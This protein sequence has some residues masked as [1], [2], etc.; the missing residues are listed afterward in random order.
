MLHTDLSP[1]LSLGHWVAGI[2]ELFEE[3]GVLLCVSEQGA[4]PDMRQERLGDRLAQKRKDLIQGSTDFL[5]LLKSER[6]LCDAGC[7]GYFSHWL[8]PEESPIRFDTR[9]YLAVLPPDQIPLLTSEEV[10]H[11]L[12]VTPE[13][14]LKF[15]ERETLP[16]IFPTYSALR[17]LAD[18]DSLES[19]FEEYGTG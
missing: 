18:F 15:C 14:A 7:L 13:R 6:L 9:F 1:E 4:P 8:T 17:T 10:T 16:M 12:W 3:V 11:S 2:R 5:T 19:L